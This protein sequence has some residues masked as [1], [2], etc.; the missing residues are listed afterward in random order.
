M[1]HSQHTRRAHPVYFVGSGAPRSAGRDTWALS[2]SQTCHRWDG[3]RGHLDGRVSQAGR[4]CNPVPLTVSHHACA[5][6]AHNHNRN[7]NPSSPSPQHSVQPQPSLRP[8]PRVPRSSTRQCNLTREVMCS[9][10]FP[11]CTS[12]VSMHRV[13]SWFHRH[14]R[15][16]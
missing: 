7:H 5:T 6:R 1:P 8:P 2:A 15:V 9:L 14:T 12:R 11:Q 16:E 10:V 13:E 3:N 4:N